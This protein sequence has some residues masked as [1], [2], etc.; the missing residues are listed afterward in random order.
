[1]K[2]RILFTYSH[3]VEMCVCVCCVCLFMCVDI[4]VHIY[5]RVE[6]RGQPQII[7]SAAHP[8]W[9]GRPVSSLS[10]RAETASVFTH[11]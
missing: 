6:A 8:C 2:R 3:Y 1:M 11:P 7:Y 5:K 4:H 10:H 9:A